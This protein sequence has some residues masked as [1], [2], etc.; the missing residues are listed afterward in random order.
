MALRTIVKDGDP[1]LKRSYQFDDRLHLLLICGAW[2][3][4]TVLALPAPRL[5]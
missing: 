2:W 4:L 5:A 3:M 1:I